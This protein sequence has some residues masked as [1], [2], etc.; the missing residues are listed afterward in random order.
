MRTGLLF[1]VCSLAFAACAETPRTFYVDAEHGDDAAAGTEVSAPWKTTA[2]VAKETYRPGDRVLFRAGSMWRVGNTLTIKGEG[3]ETAPIV[4]SRYGE[5]PRP[6]LRASIDGTAPGFWTASSNGLWTANVTGKTDVGNIVCVKRGD[7]MGTKTAAWKRWSVAEIVDE[8]DYFHDLQAGVIYFKSDRNPSEVYS[9]MELCRRICIMS[10]ARTQWVTVDSLALNYTGAHGIVGAPVQHLRVRGCEFGWIGGS[11]LGMWPD[12]RGG[13]RPVRYGNGIEFWA[14]GH[15]LDIRLENNF[16]YEV[17][18]TAMTNQGN[19][20]GVLEDMVICSNRT[21]RCEQS[22]E[23]WFTSTNYL[24]KSIELFGNRFED[25]GYG[26]SHAQRPDKNATHLLAYGFKPKVESIYYHDNYLG[27]TKQCMFW[28]FSWPTI[29]HV[30][31]DHNTYVQPGVD[32]AT[33]KGLF[34][35]NG[36]KKWFTPDFDAYRRLT[37]YD[38][39]SR[40]LT[41]EEK[42]PEVRARLARERRNW[43]ALPNG[44]FEHANPD[45]TAGFGGWTVTD[46]P[47]DLK[48]IACADGEVKHGGDWSLR[49]EACPDE[50]IQVARNVDLSDAVFKVGR[51]YRIRAWM[52][53]REG[54]PRWDFSFGVFAKGLRCLYGHDFESPAAADGWQM[55]SDVFTLPANGVMIRLM[56][57]FRH[58]AVGWVDDVTLEEQLDDGSFRPVYSAG[59]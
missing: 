55:C 31:L 56:F 14:T 37:G 24:V 6:E 7:A 22:Y 10:V 58:G 18:D 4:F 46:R 30:R 40:L 11:L 12:G 2:R 51:R 17:Y 8:G 33:V 21:V 19:Q 42:D 32:A 16:F 50:K 44:D 25:A 15:N 20:G 29:Q 13:K 43:L 26:W 41:P 5:G 59:Y 52:R 57:N 3:T 27:R 38:A 48:S 35:W 23:I 54:T 28:W 47:K 45:S 49:V 9:M 1:A 34:K 36:E 53:S 39:H